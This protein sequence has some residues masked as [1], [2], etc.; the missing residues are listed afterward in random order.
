MTRTA[1]A[2]LLSLALTIG[3]AQPS[4]A[5]DD[6]PVDPG[7]PS[8]PT[9]GGPVTTTERELTPTEADLQQEAIDE[10]EAEVAAAS[11]PAGTR[12]AADEPAPTPTA[13]RLAISVQGQQNNYYCGPASGRMILQ[14][15]GRTRS[16]GTNV[17][18]SQSAL[19]TSTYM[20]TNSQGAT[21][22][23]RG[24]FEKGLNTWIRGTSTGDYRRVASPSVN[25]FQGSLLSNI[26]RQGRPFGVSTVEFKGGKHY[27]GHPKDQTIGHWIVAYGYRSSGESGYFVDPAYTIWEDTGYWFEWGT[28][29][30]TRDFVQTNG[31][32]A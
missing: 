12:A 6:T 18:L 20:S 25:Q 14:A 16:H 28:Y 11:R 10:F 5:A 24:D 27:N 23:A 13:R 3:L 31:I 4:W 22:W 7:P 21:R 29:G 17:A 2:L 15:I 32:V 9:G 19:A 1:R 30:F 8:N 26:G